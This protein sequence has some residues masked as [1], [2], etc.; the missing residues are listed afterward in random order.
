MYIKLMPFILYTTLSFAA[1]SSTVKSFNVTTPY[2]HTVQVTWLP[3]QSSELN[4]ILMFY[5]VHFS[6]AETLETFEHK[7]NNTVF[8]ITDAHPYYTY[9]I[10]VSAVTV[11]Y[12]P[13]TP[14]IT[15]TTP[16]DGEHTCTCSTLPWQPLFE[17]HFPGFRKW[18]Q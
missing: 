6:V 18:L 14:V 2:S 12:G 4:G 11:A 10:K 3:L 15:V 1:P 7:T 17:P 13:Y 9:S 5:S 16:Q 8:I